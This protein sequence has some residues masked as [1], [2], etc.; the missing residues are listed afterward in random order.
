MGNATT[1]SR[2]SL[3]IRIMSLVPIKTPFLRTGT[4]DAAHES[5]VRERW[6]RAIYPNS[7]K[8]KVN[9]IQ[10][11]YTNFTLLSRECRCLCEATRFRTPYGKLDQRQ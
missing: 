2:I 9:K 3:I 7:C 11:W 6:K 8:P 4:P 1:K 10:R 5:S